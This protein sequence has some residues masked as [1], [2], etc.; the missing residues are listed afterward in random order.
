M[1]KWEI[2]ENKKYSFLYNNNY[3]NSGIEKRVA[4]W[5]NVLNRDLSIIDLGCGH[6][7]LEQYYDN[8]VGV[9]ISDVVDDS[10]ENFYKMSLSKV[11]YKI[12][13]KFDVAISCDV[14]EHIPPRYIDSVLKSISK[15][16]ATSYVFSISTRKSGILDEDGNNLHLTVLSF[17]DW[18]LKLEKYYKIIDIDIYDDYFYIKLIKR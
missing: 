4:E 14:M 10:K 1:N 3:P 8:Y 6:A 18:K 5:A 9:D 15:L 16:N 13:D 12:R 7:E 11:G 2:K 17:N